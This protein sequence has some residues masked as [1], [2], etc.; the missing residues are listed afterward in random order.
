M[1]LIVIVVGSH[2]GPEGLCVV[3][4]E[5][6]VL[7]I[8]AKGSRKMCSY[9]WVELVKLRDCLLNVAAVDG[10]LDILTSLDGS[11]PLLWPQVC[12][13]TELGG[14]LGVPFHRQVVEDQSIDVARPTVSMVARHVDEGCDEEKSAGQFRVNKLLQFLH[15]E[16]SER[17][18]LIAIIILPC[19]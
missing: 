17:F 18:P 4:V 2:P 5:T 8:A 13:L 19:M 6:L 7:I 3:H 9:L 10:M 1:V 16:F 14:S 12:L 15:T 11:I